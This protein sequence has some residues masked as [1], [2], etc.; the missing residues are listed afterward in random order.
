MLH[1]IANRCY[2]ST[3]FDFSINAMDTNAGGKKMFKGFDAFGKQ[4]LSRTDVGINIFD[5]CR[6]TEHTK[7][8]AVSIYFT[9]N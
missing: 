7:C 4:A 6:T 9:N 8:Y 5:G 2:D 1:A 3:T